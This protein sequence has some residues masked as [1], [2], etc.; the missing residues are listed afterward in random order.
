M[1]WIVRGRHVEQKIGSIL[2]RHF[3]PSLISSKR[4]RTEK[5]FTRNTSYDKRKGNVGTPRVEGSCVEWKDE[6]VHVGNALS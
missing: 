5:I 3:I 6:G 2:V 4:R 1:P